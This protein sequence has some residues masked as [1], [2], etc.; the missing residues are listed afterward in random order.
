MIQTLWD[1][2]YFI[3]NAQEISGNGFTIIKDVFT[4]PEVD[5]IISI[6][7]KADTSKPAFRK[8]ENLF[9]I[10]RFLPEFPDLHFLIF[11]EKLKSIIHQLFGDD[12]FVVKSIY[13]DKP[14]TSNWFVA[15]HQD[16]TISVNDKTDMTGFGPW[17]I[18]Q[19]R[20]AVQP[21]L[22]VLE[23][24]FTVRIHLDETTAENGALRVIPKS[25]LKGIYRPE[26]FDLPKEFEVICNVSAG[27]I[28][29]MR[30]LLLHASSRTTNNQARRVIHIEFSNQTLPAPLQWSE[31]LLI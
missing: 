9:A 8:H 2:N 26:N 15:Y 25:H 27:G 5:V 22:K 16:L 23:N 29:I 24:N 18:K 4:Q 14:G 19:D 31:F 17:T 21:P 12:Y 3:K 10:R 11:T 20:Y 13:F 6:I 7:D 30:P 1:N 28:M